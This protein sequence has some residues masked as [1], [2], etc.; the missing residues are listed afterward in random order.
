MKSEIPGITCRYRRT[1]YF[2]WLAL[3]YGLR[4]EI[5]AGADTCTPTSWPAASFL[6][7]PMPLRDGI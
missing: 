1:A 4:I 7:W 3:M 2:M 6:I 5:G